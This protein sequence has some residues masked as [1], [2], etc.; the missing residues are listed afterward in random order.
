LVESPGRTEIGDVQ[1]HVP[2]P[3]VGVRPRPG[4]RVALEFAEEIL[5]IERSVAEPHQ[6][7]RR[8]PLFPRKVPGQ[9]D[10]IALRVGDVDRQV[11]MVIHHPLDGCARLHEAPEQVR[12]LPAGRHQHREVVQSG[13]PACQPRAA[14]LGQAQ[15]VVAAGAERRC[16]ILAPV[17]LKPKDRLIEGDLGLEVRRSEVHVSQRGGRMNDKLLFCL[18]LSRHGYSTIIRGAG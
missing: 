7:L 13:R 8:R 10:P 17:D 16:P 6:I 14:Q 15:Q 1:M 12:Q 18:R 5:R 11:R 9:F 2:D 4:G 3:R